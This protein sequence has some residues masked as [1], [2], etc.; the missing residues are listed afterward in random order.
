MTPGMTPL[1]GRGA[2]R[3]VEPP[4][5][6][7][8]LFATRDLD[9]ARARIA[10][11]FCDHFLGL[12]HRSGTLDVRYNTAA[13][14]ESVSLNYLRYGDEVRITPGRFGSFFLVQ[15]PLA[16]SAHV[17]VGE[18]AVASD[19]RVA[20]IGS[21]TE[22]V[23][24]VWSDGCEQLLVYIRRS[25]IEDLVAPAPGQRLPVVFQPRLDLR[26][27]K[28]AAWL[29]LVRL[30]LAD[31][32]SG[33]QLFTSELVASHFEHVLMASLL[34]AQANTRPPAPQRRVGSRAVRQV[35]EL[36]ETSPE[37]PWRLAE[38]AAHAGV[39]ARALQEGFRRELGVA[40]MTQLRRIRL[41]RAHGDLT[42]PNGAVDSVAAVAAR[43]GF[44]H[45]G[46]FAQAYRVE[47]DES[48][49]QT[50]ARY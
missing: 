3:P 14:G 4:L 19:R 5:A 45:L 42:S 25:A 15:I 23:D 18:T 41:R 50:L 10:Q 33:G 38:L 12:T 32:E 22:P 26:S 37:V 46:R 8:R 9:E 13:I 35:L 17:R 24:M 43:W 6:R 34:A 39:S 2:P 7:H 40:P 11:Q 1:A 31:V 28:G 21:P 48:P 20:S 16:G 29:G 36:M 47:Y 27:P 49:S 30:A 44:G